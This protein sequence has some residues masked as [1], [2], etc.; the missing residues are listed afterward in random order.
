MPVNRCKNV[1]KS[2]SK[3]L[4]KK[5]NSVKP[6]ANGKEYEVANILAA[7]KRKGRKEYLILWK[8]YP[9]EESTWEPFQCLNCPKIL[10]V[11]RFY[12]DILSC[13]ASTN[14]KRSASFQDFYKRQRK[15]KTTPSGPSAKRSSVSE[16]R[17]KP[18]HGLLRMKDLRR[19]EVVLEPISPGPVLRPHSPYDS[20]P[21]TSPV[22]S[23]QC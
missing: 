15:S 8:G 16:V 5:G 21:D 17:R 10:R 4:E 22:P 13:Q 19:P 2:R 20:S 3:G 14:L 6:C 12:S 7:R 11:I 23:P 1:R 9:E 18:G